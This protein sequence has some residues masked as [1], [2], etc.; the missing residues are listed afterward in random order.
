MGPSAPASARAV[1]V[2]LALI[3]L[4][5][6]AVELFARE[7]VVWMSKVEAREQREYDAAVAAKPSDGRKT[8]LMLGNSLMGEGVRFDDV[9]AA[10]EPAWDSRK[11][12]IDDTGYYDFFYGMRRLYAQGARYSAILVFLTPRQLVRP[13]VRGD[14]F[15]YRLMSAPDV[16]KVA[17]DTGLS[18]TDASNML[19]AN[20]SAFYGLRTVIRNVLLGR[21][22]PV[23]PPLMSLITSGRGAPLTSQEI[24]S[25]AIVRLRAYRELASSQ[26]SRIILVMPPQVEPEGVDVT[27]L[28]ASQAGITVVTVSP[29]VTGPSD[30]RDGFHL[31][32]EGARKYTAAL[33][34]AIARALQ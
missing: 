12:Y 11:L 1:V 23:L 5:L 16:V 22:L 29:A 9:R 33:I 17:R 25:S 14:Y 31:N 19:F 6:V 13:G 20:F 18:R 21:L 26:N 10:L 2:L 24:Y 3:A 4:F 8:V 15:A 34:P 30:F 32:P 7:G 27:Q 28:A